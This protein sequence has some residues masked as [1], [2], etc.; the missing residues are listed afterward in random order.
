MA[1]RK[2]QK[3]AAR[4]QRLD[5]ERVRAERA[6]RERRMRLL[7]GVVI[8]A[9]AIVA[10]LIA[11]SS[12]GSTPKVIKPTSKQAVGEAATVAKL[13]AGIPQSGNRLGSASAPVTVTEFGDLECPVC[14][15][16]ALSSENQL[17][18]D[19]VRTGKV[20]LIY[21]SL[22][23]A[24]ENGPD[25]NVF[26]TQQ[27]AAY[28]AGAQNLGWNYIELFYHEQGTEDTAYVTPAYLEGLA[29]QISGLNFATWNSQRF[30]PTY[31]SEVQTGRDRGPVRRL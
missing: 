27:A 29:K 17:I 10:V 23:T 7:G 1:S 11:I 28:A 22:P 16:F 9:V 13:L 19:D 30:N 21:K 3:E 18:T 14:K 12:G 8:L 24:T 20:Q 31:T 4:Q 26:P 2:E 5:A 6:Q 25:P 15:D